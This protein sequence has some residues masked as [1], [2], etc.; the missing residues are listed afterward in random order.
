MGKKTLLTLCSILLISVFTVTT[1]AKV[2][3]EL[4]GGLA[5]ISPDEYNNGLLYT[6]VTKNGYGFTDA[7]KHIYSGNT[8]TAG[9]LPSDTTG[10]SLAQMFDG[11]ALISIF[12]G[13]SFAIKLRGDILYS[14]Y[15]DI[16]SVDSIDCLYSHTVLTTAFFG[17]GL[18]Y[19]LN[20]SP[21]LAFFLSADGGMFMN[22]GSYYEAAA[23]LNDL[24]LPQGAYSVDFNES[25]FGGHGEAGVQLLFS[26]SV[27]VSLYGGYR[28]GKMPVTF[29][30]NGAV[31][32]VDSKG[33]TI[34]S[35]A[36][37]F[38]STEL[39]ISGAYFGGGLVFYFGADKLAAAG[40]T[41]AAATA[42]PAETGKISK[43][44]QYG[45]YYFKQ[46]NYKYALQYYTGAYKLAPAPK[47]LKQIGFCHYYLKDKAKA[48]E[49]LQKY[50]QANPNDEAIK[51][52]V[53]PLLAQ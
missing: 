44:E 9:N 7:L 3:L 24:G 41:A 23:K 12:L 2:G 37:V 45:N 35:K 17:A 8:L 21:N 51:K 20:L 46:K 42:V 16:V 47:L 28:Y 22:M 11:T 14:D 29:P 1:S 30:N 32:L 52:W 50:L 36:G 33:T 13:D 38:T 19:Y 6:N 53:A 27:G 26:E 31:T 40:S 5:L 4:R 48:L 25:F 18:A 43:Y 49:Y 10:S 39:D 34:F 15:D